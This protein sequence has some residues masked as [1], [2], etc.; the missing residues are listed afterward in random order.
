LE[1][2]RWLDK[3]LKENIPTEV[4]AFSFNLYEP[5]GGFGIEIIGAAYFDENDPD[6]ACDEIWEPKQRGIEIPIEFSGN[7]WEECLKKMESIARQ[8]L[9][10]G[11]ERNILLASEGVGIGFVD[12]DISIIYK[13][14]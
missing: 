7:S 2:E 8:Y 14:T 6:W 13:N 12:G 11:Q 1:F 5:P 3:S 10:Q 4:K 9:Q